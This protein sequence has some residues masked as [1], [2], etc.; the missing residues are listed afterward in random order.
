VSLIFFQ[1]KGND[2]WRTMGVVILDTGYHLK[3]RP[4]DGL[5]GFDRAI[6]LEITKNMK[7]SVT[8]VGYMDKKE[9]AGPMLF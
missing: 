2:L 7:F 1:D 5:L 3:S 4:T 9:S 6:P 8:F